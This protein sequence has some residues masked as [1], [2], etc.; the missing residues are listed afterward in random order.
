MS[1]S[2]PLF[3][4]EQTHGILRRPEHH[5]QASSDALGW[6]SLY[7][8]TQRESAY[9]GSFSPVEDH[10]IILHLDGPVRVSRE[11]DGNR[12]QRRVQPGGL[13]VLPA[14]HGFSVT[15]DG[16]LSTVHAY[17]RG[18]VVRE[19]TAELTKGDPASVEIVPRLG[20]Q[21]ESLE[22][23][24]RM[25]GEIVREAQGGAWIGDSLAH[26]LAAT[27]VRRHSTASR[28]YAPAS[29]GLTRLQ[30]SRVVDYMHEHL[31]DSVRL[32]DM[33]AALALSPVHFARQ[34]RLSTGRT[35]HQHLLG[36]RIERA[37]CLLASELAIAEVA[38]R[39]G[40]SHQEHLTRVFGRLVG[41]T[42]NAYRR[43]LDAPPSQRA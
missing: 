11:L 25:A 20:E 4:V 18:S 26:V 3:T 13:F 40:F 21:D 34:F 9:Q 28:L 1:A 43:S 7:A 38:V 27:L 5:V 29:H 31:D 30:L 33:A 22:S 10:L 2:L 42:P 6:T 8:S 19:A 15:L 24:L 17:V 14:N 37:K 35:P 39:C 23:T 41:V 36:L 16:A 12:L 32:S